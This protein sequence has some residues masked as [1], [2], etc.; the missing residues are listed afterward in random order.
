VRAEEPAWLIVGL[1]RKPHGTRGELFVESLTD[2][3]GDVFVSGVVLRPGDASG[4]VPDPDAP[5]LRV[6]SARPFRDGWLMSFAGVDDRGAA[7]RLR[8][9]DLLIERSRL[10]ALAEGEVFRHQLIGMQVYTMGGAH[11]GEVRAFFEVR[12]AD[13]LEVRTPTGAVLVPFHRHLVREVDV[14]GGRIVIDP[15]EGLLDQ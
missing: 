5:G 3:P 14:E 10:P 1:V 4:R 9:R 11:V 2:H 7:D 13:L 12:P 8:G 6:L 15:P